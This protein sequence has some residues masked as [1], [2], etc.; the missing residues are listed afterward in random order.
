MVMTTDHAS[1]LCPPCVHEAL[2]DPHF[3]AGRPHGYLCVS[4][5]EL[6]IWGHD[7]SAARPHYFTV[8][9]METTLKHAT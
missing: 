3:F 1:S 8:H 5:C 4:V 7:M 6:E 2:V 9:S